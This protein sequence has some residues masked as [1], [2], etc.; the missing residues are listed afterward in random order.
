MLGERILTGMIGFKGAK[1]GFSSMIGLGFGSSIG[2]SVASSCSS[3]ISTS[4]SGGAGTS[5]SLKFS[6]SLNQETTAKSSDFS[7]L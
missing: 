5:I 6:V 1:P 7:D 4:L 2:F 3:L